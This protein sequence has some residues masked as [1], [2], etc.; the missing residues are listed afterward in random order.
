MNKKLTKQIEQ[1]TK[2]IFDYLHNTKL[3]E[4]VRLWIE[5]QTYNLK[6]DNLDEYPFYITEA[7]Q[8]LQDMIDN[9]KHNVN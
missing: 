7:I 8:D 6:R 2:I 4:I 9:F 1:E 3:E 5:R